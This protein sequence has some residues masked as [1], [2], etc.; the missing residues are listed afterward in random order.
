M[1]IY[2]TEEEKC[3]RCGDKLVDG[4]CMTCGFPLDDD[5]EF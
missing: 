3:P 1:E 4:F 5:E 2:E